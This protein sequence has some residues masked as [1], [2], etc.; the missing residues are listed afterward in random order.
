MKFKTFI[1]LQAVV[2]TFF[3]LGTLFAAPMVWGLYGINVEGHG[4]FLMRF[5]GGLMLANA[6]LSWFFRDVPASNAL[7]AI[8]YHGFVAWVVTL[9]V[10]LIA[11]FDGTSNTLGWSNVGL[12]VLFGF[13]WTYFAFIKPAGE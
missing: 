4:V 6:V 1:T 8:A 11:Q 10:M 2:L 9:V 5:L 7:R 3:G 12:C 13:G